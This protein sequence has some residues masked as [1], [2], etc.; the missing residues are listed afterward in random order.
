MTI[1]KEQIK[2]L[3]SA[4]ELLNYL[5][6][7]TDF[8]LSAPV[9][10]DKIAN[11]LGLKIKYYIDFSEHDIVGKI[12][13][14]ENGSVVIYIN[15]LQNSYEPRRRFTLAHEIG[16]YFHH[17]SESRMNFIDTK[18]SMSRSQSYWDTIESEANAFAAQLLM[19]K[20]LILSEGEKI[21][22]NY[23]QNNNT[24]QIP[25]RIFT[26][27]MASLFNVSTPA[28]KYRLKNLGIIK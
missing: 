28:M 6:S 9:N 23:L 13:S 10:V 25:S 12:E 1:K 16:H 20:S 14:N 18:K 19:P 8:I 7:E 22:S 2:D 21:I 24:K 15:E 4:R 26:E 5:S 27:Q 3:S 17:F 11:M